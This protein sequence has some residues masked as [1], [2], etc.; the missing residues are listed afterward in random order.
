MNERHSEI[1]EFAPTQPEPHCWPATSVVQ[2]VQ[3]AIDAAFED[4]RKMD[5]CLL[6]GGPQAWAN[7]RWPE[8]S[9]QEMATDFHEVLGQS[10]RHARPT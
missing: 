1:N 10:H 7:L 3:T 5:S 6:L 2:Q 9:L 8:S 4:G